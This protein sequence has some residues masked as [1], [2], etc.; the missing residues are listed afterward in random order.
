MGKVGFVALVRKKSETDTPKDRK[1]AV[2]TS[3][4]W[5]A[6]INEKRSFRQGRKDTGGG[7]PMSE[8]GEVLVQ[9]KDLCKHFGVTVALNHVNMEIKRGEIRGLIGENGSG[10][11][12]VTT[13]IAGIQ[14]ATSGEIFYKG[15]PWKPE[16]SLE[17]IHAGIGIIVQE[18]GTI[19][20]ITVA[21]NI[22]LGDYDQFRVGPI[23]SKKKMI[24]AANKA[25]RNIGVT[26]IDAG[27]PTRLYN[28]EQRKLI[29]IAKTMAHDPEMFVVDETTT[30]LSE[31]GREI[32]YKLMRKAA[33]DNK[34]VIFISH[35]LEEIMDKCDTLTVLRD[36]DI[37]GSLDKNEYDPDRIKKMMIGRDVK[38]DYYRSD[39]DGYSSEVVL[40]AEN[41]TTMQNLLCFDIELHKGEILGIGGLSECGM[42]TLG[43]ALYGLEDVLTGKV[44][45]TKDDVE[46]K[47][48]EVAFAHGMG[49][50]SKNRDQESLVLNGTIGVNIQSTGYKANRGL[51]I[52][53]SDKKEKEYAQLQVDELAIKC[54]SIFQPVSAM[55]GGNKQKVVFGKWLAADAD[56][57]ILDCPT[58]GVDIGVKASMYKLINDMK[59]RGKSIVLISEELPELCGM[60]DRLIIMKDGAITGEFW[61]TDGF[62]STELIDCMI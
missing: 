30:A 14:Q 12:T 36:G 7:H 48:P 32:L 44:T 23:I 55:S 47:S 54:N 34:A 61:R 2:G 53:I 21:E 18:M 46:V 57:L 25:L 58:R 9:V 10:K 4:V 13:I 49:Y 45:L 3:F 5:Y 51:G 35:D 38:G 33:D 16:T 27:K 31:S 11:S 37:I 24:D 56:I 8:K 41:L 39:L 60:S 1:V 40:R 19:P 6:G 62:D 29:E 22:F 59:K 50:V 17:A 20:N 43:R 26:D 42:H 52:F 28:M 15:K